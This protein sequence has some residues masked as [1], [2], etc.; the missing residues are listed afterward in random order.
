MQKIRWFFLVLCIAA[1]LILVIQNNELASV[2]F[3][4][5]EGTLPMSGML[6]ASGGIGFLLG[7]LMTVSM[8]RS[9]KKAAKRKKLEAEA[10]KKIESPKVKSESKALKL[11]TLEREVTQ[12]ETPPRDSPSDAESTTPLS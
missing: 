10:A 8:L 11:E 4:T 1:A 7:A 3:L 12:P 9:R 2:K 5:L 6:L